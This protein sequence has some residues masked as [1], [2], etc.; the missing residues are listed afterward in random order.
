MLINL[1]LYYVACMQCKVPILSVFY[2]LFFCPH[3]IMETCVAVHQFDIFIPLPCRVKGRAAKQTSHS[4][5]TVQ[6]SSSHHNSSFLEFLWGRVC[7]SVVN[8][9]FLQA[10]TFPL[11]AHDVIYR[12]PVLST[13]SKGYFNPADFCIVILHKRLTHTCTW[14]AHRHVLCIQPMCAS[15][16]QNFTKGILQKDWFTCLPCRIKIVVKVFWMV[17]LL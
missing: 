10:Q 7:S 15:S 6:F 8:E 5:M 11:P 14:K 17:I 3:A 2:L 1:N 4:V 9:R 16:I 12:I 13:S